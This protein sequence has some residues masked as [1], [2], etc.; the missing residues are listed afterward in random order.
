MLVNEKESVNFL[1]QWQAF[2]VIC[3]S[4]IKDAKEGIEGTDFSSLY[5]EINPCLVDPPHEIR[6]L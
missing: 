1:N 5:V 3:L 4:F 6:K 2:V